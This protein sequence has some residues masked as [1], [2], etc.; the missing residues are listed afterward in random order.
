MPGNRW[1]L[2]DLNVRPPPAA[3]QQQVIVPRRDHRLSGLHLVPV[4]GF[5]HLQIT[6]FVESFGKGVGGELL[7]VLDNGEFIS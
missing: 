7:H 2:L 3:S 6:E 4:L 5:P 1:T